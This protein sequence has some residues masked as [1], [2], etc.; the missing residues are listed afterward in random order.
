V[1]VPMSALRLSQRRPDKQVTLLVAS[2]VES[3]TPEQKLWGMWCVA[4]PCGCWAVA[5]HS[6]YCPIHSLNTEM[7]VMLLARD[8]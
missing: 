2:W 8:E 6:G 7:R 3:S 5:C 1:I 4:A